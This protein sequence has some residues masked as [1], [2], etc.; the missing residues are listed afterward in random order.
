VD[1][2]YSRIVRLCRSAN[3]PGIE[4][5]VSYGTPS[6]KVKGKFMLRIREAGILV[7][8][9]ELDEKEFLM[10]SAPDIY[11]ETDHYVGWPGLLIRL[12]NI[13]DEELQDRLVRTWKQVASKKL[14]AEFDQK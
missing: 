11:F 12:E 2:D 5:T 14:V 3:L 1:V 7:I 13:S 8:R 9:C 10:Q 6:I 4:E